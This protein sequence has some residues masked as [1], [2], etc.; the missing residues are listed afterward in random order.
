LHCKYW[1]ATLKVVNASYNKITIFNFDPIAKFLKK[2]VELFSE[3]VN[4]GTA[5]SNVSFVSK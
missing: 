1:T 4:K 3:T 5:I 2:K